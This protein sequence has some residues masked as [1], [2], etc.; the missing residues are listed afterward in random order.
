MM[1]L[2]RMKLKKI[3]Y[4]MIINK[5]LIGLIIV[6][7][8]VLLEIYMHKIQVVE[9][10][11][12]NKIKV[13]RVN[14]SKLK[15]WLKDIRL[16]TSIIKF[17]IISRCKYKVLSYK[18]ILYWSK[19]LHIYTTFRII[20]LKEIIFLL[21]LQILP[22]VKYVVKHKVF[23]KHSSVSLDVYLLCAKCAMETR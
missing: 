19:N 20:H 12:I 14:T 21:G 13:R 6:N 17:R 15:N 8:L 16:K 23:I 2:M 1:N 22:L 10:W 7:H 18:S 4:I 5:L 9:N 3:E 11:K